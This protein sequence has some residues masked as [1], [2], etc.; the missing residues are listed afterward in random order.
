MGAMYKHMLVHL[1]D[2]DM[3]RLLWFDGVNIAHHCMN[4]PLFGDVWSSSTAI[5]EFKKVLSLQIVDKSMECAINSLFY[6]Y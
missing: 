3:L 2:K 6:G 5:Y 1:E 4:V